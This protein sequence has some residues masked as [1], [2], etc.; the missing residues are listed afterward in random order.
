[1]ADLLVDTD[2]FIDH[3]RGERELRRG[4]DVVSYSVITR[5]ELFAGTPEQEE[6]VERLL[7]PFPELEVD[8]ETA[9]LAGRLRRETGVLL[10]DALVAATAIRN[11]LS[12]VTRNTKDFERV[13]DLRLIDPSER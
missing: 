2:V 9:E 8:R 6:R 1:M 12:L 3:L 10:P 4:G 7:A 5:A 13:A 11:E